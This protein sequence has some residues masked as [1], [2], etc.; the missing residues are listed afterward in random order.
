MCQMCI[1][2]EFIC[3]FFLFP[4]NAEGVSVLFLHYWYMQSGLHYF[5]LFCLSLGQSCPLVE[6]YVAIMEHNLDLDY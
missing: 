1:L 4:W 3:G 5:P 6:D 2:R